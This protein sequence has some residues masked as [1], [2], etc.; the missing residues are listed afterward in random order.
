M[1]YWGGRAH[2]L[3]T[4]YTIAHKRYLDELKRWAEWRANRNTQRFPPIRCDKSVI[5]VA[6]EFLRSKELASGTDYRR[7]L[8]KHLRRWLNFVGLSRPDAITVR[9]IQSLKDSMLQGGY[10]PRTVNHDLT[11]VK[12]LCDYMAGMGYS[13]PLAHK[14]VRKLPVGPAPDKSL[15]WETIHQLVH[16]APDYLAP[17]LAVQYLCLMRPSEVVAVSHS[18]GEW[19]ERGVFRL[20]RGKVDL[21]T[22]QPRCIIFSNEALGWLEGLQ[23]RWKNLDSYS[24]CARAPWPTDD[25]PYA[26][27]APSRLRH[28]AAKHLHRLGASRGDVDLLLGHVLRDVSVTYNPPFW[29]AL[30]ATVALLSLAQAGLS[31]ESSSA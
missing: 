20:T 8:S 13:Q 22:R 23:P 17:A 19:V 12:A 6:E 2:Y 5:E 4:N 10:K 16:T 21:K 30:R 3:G 26:G 24:Q 1:V 11:A 9:H 15:P 28:S 7:Y 27:V 31:A 29:Q 25:G 18:R 14:I